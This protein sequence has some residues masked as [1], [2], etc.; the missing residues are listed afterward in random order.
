MCNG[1]GCKCILACAH[2]VEAKG[3]NKHNVYAMLHVLFLS[4]T[5]LLIK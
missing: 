5:K 3:Q 4:G 1:I 2:F